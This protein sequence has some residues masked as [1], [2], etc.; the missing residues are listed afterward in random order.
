MFDFLFTFSLYVLTV[1]FCFI[2]LQMLP[3]K[4][5]NFMGYTYKNFEI[6][7][8]HEVPGIGMLLSPLLQIMLFSLH[9]LHNNH[10]SLKYNFHVMT[11]IFLSIYLY[12]GLML[13][14]FHYMFS[15]FS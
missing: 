6:V 8:D 1:D 12:S 13:I 2:L 9:M 7:N 3:S 14:V 11:V 4:D 5:V 10:A 15:L